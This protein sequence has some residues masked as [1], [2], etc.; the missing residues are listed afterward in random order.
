MKQLLKMNSLLFVFIILLALPSLVLAIPIP[1]IKVNGSDGPLTLTTDD[2]ISS[3]IELDAADF[4]GD[5]AD[6]WVLASTPLGLFSYDINADAWMPGLNVTYQGPLFDLIPYNLPTI[7]N[8]PEGLYTFYFGIDMVM[9]GE[10]TDSCIYCDSVDVTVTNPIPE[11]ATLLLLGSGLFG[12]GAF[13][14]KF[15]K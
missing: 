1:D 11:P 7:F 3:V 5:D 6:W 2:F 14:K 10:I 12:L 15:K 13:R 8:P 4:E 9:N